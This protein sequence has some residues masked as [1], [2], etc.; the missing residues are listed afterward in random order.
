[1]S[2]DELVA[3]ADVAA[4]DELAAL[5]TEPAIA[6]LS[7]LIRTASPQVRGRAAV[8]R[9]R[10]QASLR[11]TV[12]ILIANL[13]GGELTA[14]REAAVLLGDLGDG[15]GGDALVMVIHHPDALLA[16]AAL[17]SVLRLIG[18]APAAMN[19]Q[20]WLGALMGTLGSP[21]RSVRERAKDEVMELLQRLDAKDREA[22]DGLFV[23]VDMNW[24]WVQELVGALRAADA[25]MPVL[26]VEGPTRKWV[27]SV[28][29]SRA[30]VDVRCVESL[31]RMGSPLGGTLLAERGRS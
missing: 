2:I 7:T 30:H 21:L 3:R 6:A 19:A 10:L 25:K 17:R 16:S 24:P 23:E 31:I 22:L 27:E 14:A 15:E 12:A 1:M 20:T 13:R 28:L 29:A 8:A 18:I 11:E 4:V 26:H 9:H 5:G